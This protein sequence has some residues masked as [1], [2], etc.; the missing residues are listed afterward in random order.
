MS[1]IV[2]GDFVM[3]VHEDNE[4]MAGRV[5]YVMTNPGLLGLPGSEYSMEYAEDDKPVIVRAYK[6][7]DGAWEEQPYVFYHR[8]S[9]VVRIESLSVSV[10]MVMEVGSTG[11]GI[12]AVLSQSDMENMYAVQIG[13]SYNSDNEDEDKWNNME[14]KCWVGYEQR[15][16]KEKGGRMVPNCV[17]VGKLNEMDNNMGKAKPKYEDFI[18]PRSGGSEP[19]SEEHTSELQSLPV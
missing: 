17:P 15:G 7:E 12:P 2:E 5:E 9:E 16:M 11:S 8:M 3:F 10:D 4:I 6:A 19:R 13:K 1:N 14:K 18:K